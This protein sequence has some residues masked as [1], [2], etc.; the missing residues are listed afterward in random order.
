[1][2]YV[3]EMREIPAVAVAGTEDSFPVHRIYCVGQ[4]YA[5]HARE[6]GANPE[7][8]APFFFS[9]PADAVCPEGARLP[10]PLATEDFHH[11]IELVV[12]IGKKGTH[13][14]ASEALD[15]VFGYAVGFDLTRRDLQ[16][17]AK[18]KGRPWA[19]AK[20]FDNSAPCSA[21]H[22]VGEVGHLERGKITLSVNGELRQQGDISEMIC[23]VPEIISSLS[24]F[25]EICPGDLIFTGT[26]SGVGPLKRGDSLEG[27]VENLDRLHI[28]IV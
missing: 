7:R 6:M 12:A 21:V 18:K 16:G 13:I 2:N 3:F 27:E 8:E 25:F 1:M 10:Y 14:S 4:N 23:S 19:T 17:E 5:K 20:G 26:P 11:E 24:S 15:Y 28:T 9:K 22:S